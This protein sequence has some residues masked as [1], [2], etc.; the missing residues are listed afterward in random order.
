[1]A[2]SQDGRYTF[3]NDRLE[4][5]RAA[6]LTAEE[7]PAEPGP[8]EP[9]PAPAVAETP[10]EPPAAPAKAAADPAPEAAAGG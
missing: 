6:I 9:D 5:A 10:A 3:E 4:A 7:P 2:L 8:Q 1:M